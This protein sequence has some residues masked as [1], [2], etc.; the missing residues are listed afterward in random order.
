[1]LLAQR[2]SFEMA[3][4]PLQWTGKEVWWYIRVR[5]GLCISKE[6]A[7]ALKGV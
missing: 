3:L 5:T 7:C 1:M 2:A 6:C 4:Y